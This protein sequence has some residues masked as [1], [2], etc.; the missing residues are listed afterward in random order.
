MGQPG[1]GDQAMRRVG[2]VQRWQ[3]AAFGQ[4]GQV[5]VT[6]AQAGS[7]YFAGQVTADGNGSQSQLAGAAGATYFQGVLAFH[8]AHP[9]LAGGGFELNQ[10]HACARFSVAK[11]SGRPGLPA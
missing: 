2:M 7:L 5:V 3:Y 4:Q 10:S 8:H 6:L 11:V 9:A 1:A